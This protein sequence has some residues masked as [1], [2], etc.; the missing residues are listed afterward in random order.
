MESLARFY[1]WESFVCLVLSHGLPVEWFC[2]GGVL[3][4]AWGGMRGTGVADPV[5][6]GETWANAGC[7]FRIICRIP[8]REPFALQWTRNNQ[9]LNLSMVAQPSPP[10]FTHRCNHLYT[11]GYH[12]IWVTQL[13]M[14][15]WSPSPCWSR[16]WPSTRPGLSSIVACIVATNSPP[17]GI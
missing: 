1:S 12:R 13:W 5:Y 10:V 7:P 11:Y 15:F 3:H 8:I 6:E 17:T 9:P 2:I 16:S 14:K 4:A